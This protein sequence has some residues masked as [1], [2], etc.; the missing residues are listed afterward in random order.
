MKSAIK[1]VL[2]VILFSSVAFAD[3]GDLG[4]GNK[5]CTTNC[6]VATEPTDIETKTTE[7]DDSILTII[8]ENWDSVFKYFE[9]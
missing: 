6:L 7:S 2:V 3:D 9:N 8:Q 4:N 1:L 5:N